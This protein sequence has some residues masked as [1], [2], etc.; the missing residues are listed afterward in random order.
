MYVTSYNRRKRNINAL[1]Q[2]HLPNVWRISEML[3]NCWF[4]FGCTAIVLA[5]NI[6]EERVTDVSIIHC[7][8][9]SAR[10]HSGNKKKYR[11]IKDPKYPRNRGAHRNLRNWCKLLIDVLNAQPNWIR[12]MGIHLRFAIYYLENVVSI[13]HVLVNGTLGAILPPFVTKNNSRNWVN[14]TFGYTQALVQPPTN[15]TVLIIN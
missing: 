13:Q 3:I 2:S 5:M 10:Q 12:S 14:M 8:M 7:Q 6:T 11:N 1:T 15:F 9:N 4:D